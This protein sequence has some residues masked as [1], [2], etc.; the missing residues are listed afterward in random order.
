MTEHPKGIAR[1]TANYGDR[2]FSLYLRRSFMKS[3]GY[4]Q[5]MLD[6]PVVAICDTRSDYNNCHRT[7]PELV[8]AVKRGVLA[9]GGL[10]L[11]FPTARSTRRSSSRPPCTTATSPPS[12]PR[13]CSRR[14]PWTRPCLSAAATRRCPPSSWRR[15]APTFP[16]CSS[17]QGRCWQPRSRGSASPPARIAGATG[18][19]IAQAGWTASASRRSRAGSRPR[20]AR[21]ASWA[22][23]APWPALPRRS[24]SCPP[25]T[26]ASLQFTL[27]GCARRRRRVHSRSA[28]PRT[29]SAPRSS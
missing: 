22:R 14:S 3:M 25:G 7:V 16:A 23:R 10:P 24:A 8:E 1:R 11:A 5:A 2:D 28:L 21:A 17:S 15:P 9:A 12:I 13:R 20:P 27:T 26:R 19:P 6:R 18:R 29:R 4:S